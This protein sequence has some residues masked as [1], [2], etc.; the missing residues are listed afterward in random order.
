MYTPL[1]DKKLRKQVESWECRVVGSVFANHAVNPG[2]DPWH[3][4]KVGMIVNACD[5][6]TQ[7]VGAGGSEG[8]VYPWLHRKFEANLGFMRLCLS[9]QKK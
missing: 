5:F 1:A 9:T 8:Q 2:F 4:V 7:E 6:N 3:F